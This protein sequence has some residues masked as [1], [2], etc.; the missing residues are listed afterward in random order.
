MS[1]T[2]LELIKKKGAAFTTK[3]LTTSSTVTTHTAKTGR[4]ADGFIFET[5]IRVNTD[6]ESNMT[7]TVPDGEYYGQ[8][9]LVLMETLGGSATVDATTTTGDNATQMTAAGGYSVLA[10]H[11]STLGWAQ[12]MNSAT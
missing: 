9:L 10:W 6:S 4:T 5:V 3:S 8:T 2:N 1:A 12:I 7:I 11:G